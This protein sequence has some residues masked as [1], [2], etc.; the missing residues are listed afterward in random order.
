MIAARSTAAKAEMDRVQPRPVRDQSCH[1]QLSA[2]RFLLG[3]GIG[4][5]QPVGLTLGRHVEQQVGIARL[6]IIDRSERARRSEE[7][8]YELMSLMRISYALF[9]LNKEN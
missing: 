2:H 1:A 4:A 5:D 6:R 3:A 7:P 9:R 8:T